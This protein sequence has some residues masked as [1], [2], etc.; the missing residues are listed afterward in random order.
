[1]NDRYIFSH[2][3]EHLQ[4]MWAC[5]T[6]VC[7]LD[8]KWWF[9]NRS[10]QPI[11]LSN[12]PA[13]LTYNCFRTVSTNLFHI[14][15]ASVASP[16]HQSFSMRFFLFNSRVYDEQFWNIFKWLWKLCVTCQCP[17]TKHEGKVDKMTRTTKSYEDWV[18]KLFKLL[19]MLQ[20]SNQYSME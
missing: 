11:K 3:E 2:L 6:R 7:V 17:S 16:F 10:I 14:T 13:S 12:L 9:L 18:Q 5:T 8:A 1:M 15:F 20:N 4:W 19:F